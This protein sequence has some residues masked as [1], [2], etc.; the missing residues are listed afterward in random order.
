VPNSIGVLLGT[1]QLVLYAIYRRST[2]RK[3][4]LAPVDKLSVETSEKVAPAPDAAQ[5]KASPEA[6]PVKMAPANV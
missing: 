2:P 5:V 3:P 1:G 6:V 4:F